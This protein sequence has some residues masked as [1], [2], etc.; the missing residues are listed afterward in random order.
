MSDGADLLDLPADSA[1]SDGAMLL[2][3]SADPA[4]SDGAVLL[5]L[6]A[7]SAVSNGAKLL[8][9]SPRATH[10]RM[11]AAL[12]TSG[13]PGL[14]VSLTVCISERS[15][16]SF[17]EGRLRFGSSSMD[18]AKNSGVLHRNRVQR[19][20]SRALSSAA[21]TLPMT[22]RRKSA[23]ASDAHVCFVGRIGA[24]IGC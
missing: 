10:S 18:L 11:S 24:R 1:V 2:D 15:L 13:V 22:C 20:Q 7:D 3:L 14:S 19:Q 8:N 5:D 12:P 6:S 17:A 9:L 23:G 21:L 16:P 4:V